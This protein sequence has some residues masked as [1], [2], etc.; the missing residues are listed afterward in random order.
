MN[1]GA[2]DLAHSHELQTGG[3]G[4]WRAF[5]RDDALDAAWRS[6]NAFAP[7]SRDA[8]GEFCQGFDVEPVVVADKVVGAVMTREAEVCALIAPE[9]RRRWVSRGLIRRTVLR[10]VERFGYAIAYV[11]SYCQAGHDMA[12]RLGFRP[13]GQSH[14]GMTTYVFRPGFVAATE[15]VKN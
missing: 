2:L 4:A 15:G 6:F 3:A 12:W 10:T 11:P 7:I 5:L 9:G 1:F 14:N 13:E 8:F